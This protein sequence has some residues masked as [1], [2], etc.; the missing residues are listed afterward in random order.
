M[1][2]LRLP[3]CLFLPAN[4]VSLWFIHMVCTIFFQAYLQKVF[5]SSGNLISLRFLNPPYKTVSTLPPS[6]PYS[7][8][9]F[10]VSLKF[11]LSLGFFPYA[12]SLYQY[13]IF[14]SLRS[15]DYSALYFWDRCQLSHY[16]LR[17]SSQAVLFLSSRRE[18]VKSQLLC[19]EFKS[20]APT[21]CWC[22][23]SVLF[24]ALVM[25]IVVCVCVPGSVH[26]NSWICAWK[27]FVRFGKFSVIF[28][29]NIFCTFFFFLTSISGIPVACM[30]SFFS[31]FYPYFTLISIFLLF[32]SVFSL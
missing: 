14:M 7:S 1:A 4:F 12:S 25:F 23:V 32:S 18:H 20:T 5:L 6:K 17:A 15:D 9:W 26:N 19:K 22:N 28:S 13:I 27:S 2:V 10:W 30:L 24:P 3:V 8:E 16:F 29:L 31:V 21:S 11:N